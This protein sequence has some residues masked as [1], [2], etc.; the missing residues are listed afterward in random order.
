MPGSSSSIRE[1]KKINEARLNIQYFG[2]QVNN[3]IQFQQN[4]GFA[5]A[6]NIGKAR[7]QGLEVQG[8]LRLFDHLSVTANYAFQLAKDRANNPGRFLPGRPK[9]EVHARIEGDIKKGS[10][11]VSASW[12]DSNFLDPLNTRVVNDRVILNAGLSVKVTKN[13]TLAFEGKNLTND[14]IVDV[15]GFP[16][17]G[18]SFFGKVLFTL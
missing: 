15:V 5:R 13:I 18:R 9:H 12:I 1:R 10:A 2:R 4:V 8:T 3:L 16:L 17:P 7:I 14:Q 6:E 11:F